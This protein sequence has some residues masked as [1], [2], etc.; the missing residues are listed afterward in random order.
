MQVDVTVDVNCGGSALRWHTPSGDDGSIAY[1]D[2]VLATGSKP[3]VPPTPGLDLAIPGVCLY[4]T[5][6]DCVTMIERAKVGF[7]A[8]QLQHDIHETPSGTSAGIATPL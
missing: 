8:S 4:R 1:D 3:F 6:D 5:I 2:V 7:Q